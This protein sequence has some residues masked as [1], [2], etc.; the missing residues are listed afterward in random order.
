MNLF[1]P[2]AGPHP[3]VPST[4]ASS[5]AK[6]RPVVPVVDGLPR[7]GILAPVRPRSR[8]LQSA[9]TKG[10]LLRQIKADPGE[11][12]GP[13]GWSGG[14]ANQAHWDPARSRDW[15][16]WA[17]SGPTWSAHCG[18]EVDADDPLGLCQRHRRSLLDGMDADDD[19]GP[20]PSPERALSAG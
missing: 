3:G 20:S 19:V 12:P 10:H 17:Q 15:R 2:P 7:L 11:D 13:G 9:S 1:V 16:C 8:R 18:T 6:P 14:F 5:T 4:P